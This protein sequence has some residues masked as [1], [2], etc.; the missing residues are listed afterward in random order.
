MK[1]KKEMKAAKAAVF[2]TD[3]ITAF[4]LAPTPAVC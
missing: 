1:L 4:I 3:N 2:A